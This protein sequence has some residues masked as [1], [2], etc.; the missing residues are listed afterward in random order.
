M[1]TCFSAELLQHWKQSH[2]ELRH[3]NSACFDL[4][5]QLTHLA[6]RYT[7]LVYVMCY[8]LKLIGA[9]TL[10]LYYFAQQHCTRGFL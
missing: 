7:V 10:E 8:H 3:S 1:H 5:Y 9:V 2:N 6:D 4:E